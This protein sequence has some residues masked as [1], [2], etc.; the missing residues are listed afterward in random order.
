MVGKNEVLIQ[1][2]K[3]RAINK[4]VSISVEPDLIHIMKKNYSSN[5]Y[6]G[7]I[8]KDNKVAFADGIFDCDITQLIPGSKLDEEGYLIDEKGVTYDLY[9]AD[10]IV[11]VPLEAIELSDDT[12][13]G[14]AVGEII[15]TIY[16]GDHYQVLV[17]ND[18][19]DFVVDTIYTWNESDKVSV[20]IPSDKISLK[21]KQEAKNYIY[22]R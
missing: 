19:D 1:D 13:E 8:T 4:E 21:L 10:V 11:N 18:E 17:R 3:D 20:K 15:Q 22:E 5:V 14:Q 9:D 2:T 16:K 7:Y 6:Q 12:E